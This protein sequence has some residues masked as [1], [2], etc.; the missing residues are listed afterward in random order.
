MVMTQALPPMQ[1][2]STPHRS[3]QLTHMVP[4][5]PGRLR[6]QMQPLAAR[7]AELF[8]SWSGDM[9]LHTL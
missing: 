7:D 8:T 1:V 5:Q 3:M 6:S 4:Y 2:C 9:I